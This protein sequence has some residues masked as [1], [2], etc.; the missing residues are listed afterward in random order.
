MEDRA[1]RFRIIVPGAFL[2]TSAC[3]QRS[4]SEER[5]EEQMAQF[6]LETALPKKFH[7]FEMERLSRT[8]GRRRGASLEA[9]AGA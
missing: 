7:G 4:L 9:T 2:T 1:R 6:V 8:H 3:T 5:L